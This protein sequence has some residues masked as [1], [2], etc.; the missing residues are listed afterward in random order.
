[1]EIILLY[2]YKS[3]GYP[4]R[5]QIIDKIV[6][7]ME[8]FFGKRTKINVQNG[9]FENRILQQFFEKWF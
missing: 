6:N 9:F 8:K 5:F 2:I 4:L 1:M 3:I 7:K